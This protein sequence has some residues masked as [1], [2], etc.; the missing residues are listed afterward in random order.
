ML[1]CWWMA[2]FDG[3]L[4]V[5]LVDVCFS[6]AFGSAHRAH[7]ST[8][9]E[10]RR[11]FGA[12]CL[13]FADANIGRRSTRRC[14]NIKPG[15]SAPILPVGSSA[16]SLARWTQGPLMVAWRLPSRQACRRLLHGCPPFQRD[17]MHIAAL[18]S[19]SG[20]FRAHVHVFNAVE[21]VSC[22]PV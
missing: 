15:T 3:N 16:N 20:R 1:P 17:L 8:V 12:P 19:A 5:K 14:G 2:P 18:I 7:G 9:G 21:S 11:N 22:S 10:D 13:H 4:L 6:D